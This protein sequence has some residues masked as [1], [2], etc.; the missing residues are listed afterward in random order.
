[1]IQHWQGG[2]PGGS[3]VVFLPGCPDSR[4][5]ARTGD[6][7]ARAAGVRLISVNRPG[8]GRSA[9]AE[10][11]HLSVADEIVALA[12]RL[13]VGRFAV[14]GMSI[15]GPYALACAA[16]HPDRVTA[17][18]AVAAPGE[19]PSMDPP[20]HRDDLSPEQRDF[21]ARLARSSAAEAVELTR[22]DFQRWAAGMAVAGTDDATLAG[23]WVEG[24]HPLDARVL[25]ARPA[26]DL[27]AEVRE[28]LGCSEGYM[29]DVAATFRPWEFRLDRIGC[30]VRLWYGAQDPQASV[31]NGHWLHRHLPG[32][33]LVVRPDT[34]HLST[35][36]GHWPEILTTLVTAR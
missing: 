26:A 20:A 9:P 28:A 29:W 32:S 7:A 21:F 36:L 17:A 16:R 18:A 33:A 35:L 22:P 23:R 34:A 25:G 12:D 11:G 15:G 31:R 1:M 13:G 19:V 8:Y 5:I 24:L 3:A 14:L 10:S 2:A 30:P 27:A 6:Q 4:L